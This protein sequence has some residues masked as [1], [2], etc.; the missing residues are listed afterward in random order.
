MLKKYFKIISSFFLNLFGE[1]RFVNSVKVFP[2]SIKSINPMQ[3]KSAHYWII[4]L[5]S[6]NICCYVFI[7]QSITKWRTKGEGQRTIDKWFNFFRNMFYTK[8]IEISNIIILHIQSNPMSSNIRV[9]IKI[10]Y[11]SPILYF[12]EIIYRISI[13]KSWFILIILLYFKIGSRM[14]RH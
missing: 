8:R 2:A 5:Y 1:K 7:L 9:F 12:S 10:Y 13:I 3:K 4:C 6:E 14:G 11:I